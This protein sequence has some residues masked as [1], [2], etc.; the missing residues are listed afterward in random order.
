M[1]RELRSRAGASNMRLIHAV[2]CYQRPGS[3]FLIVLSTLREPAP[4]FWRL[5][6]ETIFWSATV[7][8]GTR[9][10]LINTRQARKNVKNQP[11]TYKR[12]LDQEQ[13]G[14]QV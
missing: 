11:E 12:F 4:W 8:V 7:A 14:A 1:E 9:A 2:K 3:A 5:S 6:A 13:L 10:S